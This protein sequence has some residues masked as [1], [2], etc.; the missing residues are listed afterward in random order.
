ML[1]ELGK[2]DLPPPLH[3]ILAACVEA[4]CCVTNL[5]GLVTQRGVPQGGVLSGIM[6][7]IGVRSMPVSDEIDAKRFSD[8]ITIVCDA[9]TPMDHPYIKAV[10]D[11]HKE[12]GILMNP[13]KWQVYTP[14]PDAKPIKLL[15]KLV[16]T[17]GIVLEKIPPAHPSLKFNCK[18]NVLQKLLV[19]RQTSLARWAYAMEMMDDLPIDQL[20]SNTRSRVKELLGVTMTLLKKKLEAIVGNSFLPSIILRNATERHAGCHNMALPKWVQRK[21]PIKEPHSLLSSE[22]GIC[23]LKLANGRVDKVGPCPLCKTVDG[24]TTDHILSCQGTKDLAEMKLT[25][26][27][28]LTKAT[29]TALFHIRNAF[30]SR[31]VALQATDADRLPNNL[32]ELVEIWQQGIS[33]GANAECDIRSFALREYNM[34]TQVFSRRKARLGSDY[35]SMLEQFRGLLPEPT[36]IDE[37]S[38]PT[39]SLVCLK[40]RQWAVRHAGS[41]RTHPD[42]LKKALQLS[43]PQLQNLKSQKRRTQKKH[44]GLMSQFTLDIDIPWPPPHSAESPT[45]PH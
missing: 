4:G 32:R 15:G 37:S 16:T 30:R 31:S 25:Y 13:E 1:E 42:L 8:D 6:Y 29:H 40:L 21:T 28:Y 2:F 9:S 17:E 5:G 11:Y 43:D 7:N 34:T 35:P 45:F 23:L 41:N 12:R 24:N 10:V 22:D 33:S 44:P 36:T 18:L 26:A 14:G 20:D 3:S 19:F 39:E 38:L 27:N